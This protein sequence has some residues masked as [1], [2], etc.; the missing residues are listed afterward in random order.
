MMERANKALID[1][2]KTKVLKDTI[3]QKG[4]SEASIL[5]HYKLKGFEDMTMA[6]W[7][8]AMQLLERYP[9]KEGGK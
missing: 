5:G 6:H 2:V 4:L 3:R 7:T 9:D 8:N 1:R